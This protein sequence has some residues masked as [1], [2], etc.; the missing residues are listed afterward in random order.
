MINCLFL[1]QKPIGDL[2]FNYLTD[3]NFKNLR[4]ASVVS[5]HST[6]NWWKT[7]N[8]YNNAKKKNIPF[9][10]NESRHEKEIMSLIDTNRIELI[11]SV[12]HPWIIS[13]EIINRVKGRSFNLHNAKLPEYRGYNSYNYAILNGESQYFCTLHY[14]TPEVDVGPIVIEKGF[15]VDSSATAFSLY[16]KSNECA[17][18]IFREFVELIENQQTL[19]QKKM[20]GGGNFYSR[21]SLSGLRLISNLRDVDE[22]A[23]ISRAMYFPPF[24]PAFFLFNGV[25]YHVIPE[26]AQE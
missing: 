20:I 11:I 21:S 22:V 26:K 2:C 25:K 15:N 19:P 5:N 6:N 10:S 1:G 23:R 17:F 14:L 9:L 24:E 4:I 3:F 12:Q 16:N 13:E 8:I 7:N 18:T